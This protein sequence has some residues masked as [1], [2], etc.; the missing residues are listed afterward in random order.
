M[1]LNNSSFQAVDQAYGALGVSGFCHPL[2]QSY[3]FSKIPGTLLSL[4]GSKNLDA[5]PADCWIEGH[6][7]R[8]ILILLDGFSWDLLEQN[9]LTYPFLSR[10]FKEGIVSK[11]T[12]QFPST[13]AAHMT[14]LC[15]SLE[16][17]QSAIFE[18]FIYEPSLDRIVAPLR[19]SYAGD[20]ESETLT[21]DPASFF[22]HGTLF[23]RMKREGIDSHVFLPRS[24]ANSSYSKW[25]FN[26]A[27]ISSY[28]LFAEGLEKLN[29]QL[30]DQTGFF[31][32]YFPGVDS[33]AHH[34]GIE[35]KEFDEM[36]RSSCL[37]LEDFF[38][39][40]ATSL[41]GKNSYL[42]TSDHGMTPIDPNKTIYINRYVPEL[43]PFL[44][45][46]A[47]GRPLTPA[48]SCRDY[49]L[50]LLEEKIEEARALLE[51]KFQGIAKIVD[52]STL[53][54]QGFFG[55][56]PISDL[57]TQRLGPLVILPF[58]NHS[59]WWHEEGRFEQKFKAMHGGLTKKEM[60]IFLL[61]QAP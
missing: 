20:Q 21:L 32:I 35:S 23:Q 1:V 47:D 60:E 16:V 36:V 58:S 56:P 4:L 33:K 54:Q 37:S 48:G 9:Y 8:V 53:V 18:W 3:S 49:F 12:S 28:D 25:M 52:S 61:F 17:G 50:Y 39:R 45:V 42:V 46:G 22:P 29:S 2:Y 38:S 59:I 40:S 31:C 57:L 6:Y 34:Y 14:T 13:T 30:I 26:G 44:R 19:Y 43:T 55:P 11:L 41:S 24:I 7:D 10:F 27:K 5:L 51:E 15:T